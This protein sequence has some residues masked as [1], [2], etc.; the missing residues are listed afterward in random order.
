MTKT[1]MIQFDLNDEEQKTIT[2]TAE[3]MRKIMIATKDGYDVYKQ[4]EATN[5]LLIK[6][7]KHDT[8]E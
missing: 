1:N 8:F 6:L 3:I 5:C 2:Q 7:L 4:A